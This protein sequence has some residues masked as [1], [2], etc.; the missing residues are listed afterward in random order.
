MTTEQ[1][2]LTARIEA[3]AP[4]ECTI[5]VFQNGGKAGTLCVE[6][7]Q[8]EAVVEL[9]NGAVS[10]KAEVE[11]LK[12]DATQSCPVCDA[13]ANGVGGKWTEGGGV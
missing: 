3:T 11:R 5:G 6:A 10:N 9:I 2:K 8:A 13:R 4:Q 12:R 1:L 7:N